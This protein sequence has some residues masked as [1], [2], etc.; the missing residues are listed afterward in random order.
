MVGDS[1]EQDL[2]LYTSLANQYPHQVRNIFIRDV[3]TS[4]PKRL[5]RRTSDLEQQRVLEALAAEEKAKR[6]KN[7]SSPTSSDELDDADEFSPNNPLDRNLPSSGTLAPFDEDGY[8]EVE[9]RVFNVF[10]DRV[11]RAKSQLPSGTSL[12]IFRTGD[13]CIGKTA[14]LFDDTSQ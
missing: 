9:R 13:E 4:V 8:T 12:H 7:R 6:A 10:A 5:T 14:G 2:E 1:G 11:H 3:T